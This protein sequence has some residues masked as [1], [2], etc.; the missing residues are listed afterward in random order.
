MATLLWGGAAVLLAFAIHVVVWRIRV[1]QRQTRALLLIFFGTLFAL[2][3]GLAAL[4]GGESPLPL[5]HHTS[6][7]VQIVLFGT[8]C[9]LGYVITYS[10][11]EADSPTL[12]MIRAIAAAGPD[13]LPEQQFQAEMGDDLLIQPRLDDLVRDE[14]LVLSDERYQFTPKGRRFIGIFLRFRRLLTMGK[15]G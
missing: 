10:A 7:F 14:M 4:P 3:V 15:G 13:G 1:P 11:V 12:V 9:A 2:L 5:P 8:A 6:E